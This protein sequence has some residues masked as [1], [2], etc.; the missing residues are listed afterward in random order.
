MCIL[1]LYTKES[2]GLPSGYPNETIV[3]RGLRLVGRAART[4]F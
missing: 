3:V 1:F 4:Y 2:D